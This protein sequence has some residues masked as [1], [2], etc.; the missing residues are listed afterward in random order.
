MKNLYALLYL[1]IICLSLSCSKDNSDDSIDPI[2][3]NEG[4]SESPLVKKATISTDLNVSYTYNI[5]ELLEDINGVQHEVTYAYHYEYDE[6]NRVSQSQY[7]RH[8]G[9]SDFYSNSSAIYNEA[10]KLIIYQNYFYSYKGQ[11]VFVTQSIFP[12]G[13]SLFLDS[14]GR[15][16]RSLYSGTE[17]FYSYDSF[18]NLVSIKQ[19]DSGDALIKD[20]VLTYD[21]RK[22]PY[23]KQLESLYL[24]EFLYSFIDLDNIKLDTYRGYNFPFTKNNLMSITTN[25]NTIVSY[26]YVYDETD[27]YPLQFSQTTNSESIDCAFTYF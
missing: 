15:V 20:I 10:G 17:I 13:F 25:A 5:D 8:E 6:M 14:Q 16:E 11:E 23:Y 24:S 22:N 27:V 2:D 9:G 26:E 12:F 1:F 7:E 19:Y 18:D 21:I 3:K 4:N